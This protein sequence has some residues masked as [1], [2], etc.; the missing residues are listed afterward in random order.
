MPF[1]QSTGLTETVP[2]A[3][4]ISRIHPDDVHLGRGVSETL[5]DGFF[6]FFSVAEAFQVTRVNYTKRKHKIQKQKKIGR[7]R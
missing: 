3:E 6:A 4:A 7:V 5:S 1:S 2:A